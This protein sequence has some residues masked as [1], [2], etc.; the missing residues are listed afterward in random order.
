MAYRRNTG[1]Q[2]ICYGCGCGINLDRP[3]VVW[4]VVRPANPQMSRRQHLHWDCAQEVLEV[5]T[6]QHELWAGTDR[7]DS[8]SE[9]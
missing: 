7:L 6:D 9:E 3:H 8:S 5:L 1:A 2:V 4:S